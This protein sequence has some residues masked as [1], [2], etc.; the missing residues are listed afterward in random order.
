MHHG[1][2]RHLSCSRISPFAK[3]RGVA[4]QGQITKFKLQPTLV[5]DSVCEDNLRRGLQALLADQIFVLL[6]PFPPGPPPHVPEG[7]KRCSLCGE[8]KE[9][10]CFWKGRA[11][12][13]LC[14][15]GGSRKAYVARLAQRG[16]QP[17]RR[18]K[19]DAIPDAGQNL[20]DTP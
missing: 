8:L 13:K 12:C 20:G 17:S 3:Y 10:S 9:N 18:S 14:Y 11:R 7:Y 6:E 16:A 4:G 15:G 1:G 2:G 5:Q 19:F